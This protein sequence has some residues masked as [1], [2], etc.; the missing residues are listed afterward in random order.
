MRG[1]S[2]VSFA[3]TWSFSAQ[4]NHL[5]AAVSG[6]DLLSTVRDHSRER[7]IDLPVFL[8]LFRGHRNEILWN[9]NILNDCAQTNGSLM[10]LFFAEIHHPQHI[11]IT[12]PVG[13][14]RTAD[15]NNQISSG[16]TAS[17]IRSG[18]ATPL[19]SCRTDSSL[20]A[21]VRAWKAE[22]SQATAFSNPELRAQFMAHHQQCARQIAPES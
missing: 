19:L 1:F 21:T 16:S 22:M 7:T 17:T 20:G 3:A 4:S 15:P 11:Q 18:R 10:T 2:K 6:I 13:F 14:P 12:V 8:K 9:R 5:F